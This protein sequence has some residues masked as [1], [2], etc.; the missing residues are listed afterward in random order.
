VEPATGDGGE[1]WAD[2]WAG[3]RVSRAVLRAALLVTPYPAARAIRR[4]FG[5]SGAATNRALE[6]RAPHDVEWWFDEPSGPAPDD[7]FDLYRPFAPD[8]ARPV[9]PAVVWVHGGAFVGGAKEDLRGWSCLLAGR[10]FAVVAPAYSRAPEAEYPAPVQQVLD[11]LAYFDRDGR[12]LGIDPGRVVLAGD[13]AGAHIAAQ[14]AACL[15]DAAYADTVGVE[16]TAGATAPMG[17]V[18]CC[19]LYDLALAR[20]DGPFGDSLAAVLWSYSGSRAWSTSRAFASW[21]VVHHV[22][23]SFPPALLTVGNADP[24]APHTVALA[25]ALAAQGVELDAV[26]FAPDHEPALGHEYQFDLSLDDARET[27]ERIVEFARRVTRA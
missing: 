2:Q 4:R 7:R 22:T 16:V 18:L 17:V 1:Q 15:A 21:S 23:P 10:G 5:A 27:F 8:D 3:G 9:L 14:V 26:V 20:P 13:S 11:L 25:E 12:R 6:A 24:L 19:G